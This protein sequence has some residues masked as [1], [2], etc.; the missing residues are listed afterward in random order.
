MDRFESDAFETI[1]TL[2]LSFPED[3][4]VKVTLKVIMLSGVRSNGGFNPLILNPVPATVA[5]RY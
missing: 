4:G 5:A 1:E 2:P 3:G